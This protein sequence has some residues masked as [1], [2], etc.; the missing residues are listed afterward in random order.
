MDY[1]KKHG[2]E[3]EPKLIAKSDITVA[4]AHALTDYSLKHN[5][6]S[7]YFGMGCNIELFNGRKEF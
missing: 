2:L 1:W 6:N 5:S 7:Y 4:N 3:L